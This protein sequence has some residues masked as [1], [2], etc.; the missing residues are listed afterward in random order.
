MIDDDDDSSGEE[1]DSQEE[2]DAEPDAPEEDENGVT[3]ETIEQ[4]AVDQGGY[5]IDRITYNVIIL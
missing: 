5:R 4:D 1:A 2:Q 3:N